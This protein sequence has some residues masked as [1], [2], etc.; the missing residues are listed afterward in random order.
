MQQIPFFYNINIYITFYNKVHHF[1]NT[2]IT[3]LSSLLEKYNYIYKMGE[4]E[5]L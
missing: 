4:I 1:Q 3:S 5:V 2:H